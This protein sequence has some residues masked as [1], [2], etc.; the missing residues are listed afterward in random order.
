LLAAL[1]DLEPVEADG[2]AEPPRLPALER[3]LARAEPLP[4]DADWRRF[5]LGALGLRAPGDELPLARTIARAGGLDDG[6]GTWLVATPVHLVAT[7]SDVRMDPAGP[8]PLEAAVASA[9]AAAVGDAC[10]DPGFSLHAVGGVLLARFARP[11]EVRTADPAPL[12]G[13]A[14]DG[15]LPAGA[16]GG[17]LRRRMT[18]LQMLLH[19]RAWRAGDVAVNALW[20]WGAGRGPIEGRAAWPAL[21]T[22]DPFLVALHALD[23]RPAPRDDTRLAT[24]RLAA[25]GAEGDAFAAA[26][27]AW[28]AP[29]EAALAAGTVAEATVHFAGRGWR[30]RRAP[31]W[32][33]WQRARPRPWWELAA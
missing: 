29:L 16:D 4:G 6:E 10:G 3:L 13:R 22:D 23:A 15:R 31:R 5:V 9:L 2:A 28:F 7:L 24:W 18:E 21:E 11:L 1:T 8:L 14:I 30:V 20:L 25:L 19:E 32:R 12:A 27:R 33:W 26:E 17:V